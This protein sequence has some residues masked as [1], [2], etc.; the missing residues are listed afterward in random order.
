MDEIMMLK[1]FWEAKC[2]FEEPLEGQVD[3]WG[4][5]GFNNLEMNLEW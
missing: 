3:P 5:G 1:P 2:G 4:F